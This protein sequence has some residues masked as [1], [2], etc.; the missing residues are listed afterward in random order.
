MR[1]LFFRPMFNLADT[2]TCTVAGVLM[3]NGHWLASVPVAIVGAAVS[4]L[5]RRRLPVWPARRIGR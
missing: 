3:L 1:D 4:T 2:F 5:M